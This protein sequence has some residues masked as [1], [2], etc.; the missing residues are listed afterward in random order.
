MS[1]LPLRPISIVTLQAMAA[2][3]V[4]AHAWADASQQY[5]QVEF[6]DQFLNSGGTDKVDISRFN[7]GQQ[8]LPG[9][10][11]AETFVNEV[12]RGRF[13]VEIR[14]SAP[15]SSEVRPCFNADLLERIGVDLRKLSP[16]TTAMLASP[17]N[18]CL[19]LSDLIPSAFASFDGGEQRLDISIPQI[20]MFSKARGY[21]DPKYWD[22][23]VPAA[24][25][26]YNA[27]AYHSSASGYTNDSQYLGLIGGLNAGPWR[28]RYQGN[29]T[30]SSVGGQ[31]YQTVQTYVQRGFND[32]KSQLT[33]GDTFTDG[34]LF[35]SYGVRGVTLGTDD[36]MYPE[37][38][39]GYA[40]IVRGIANSNAR[41]QVR[42]N[43]NVIYETTVAPG[44]FEIT[45]LYP[46]GYGGNL[47]VIVT[48]ADGSQHISTVPYA[49]TVNA[50][51]PGITRYNAMI[52]QYR[53]P[54][55][56]IHPF[57]SQFTIQRGISN[58]LTLYG[59]FTG[60]D[61]YFAG[62][63]GA[64]INTKF[65][66]FGFDAT[67]ATASFAGLGT[68]NGMSFRVS[69]SQLLEPTNTNIAIAAYRYS[70]NGFFS[71]SDAMTMRQLHE[72]SQLGLMSAMQKSRMQFT[73]NQTLGSD[74]RF[75]S[76]YAIGSI[77]NYWNRP[78][79]DTQLQI[80][81]SNSWKR[82]TYGASFVR[83]YMVNT[84]KWDN[85]VMVNLM[86]PLGLGARAPL[87]STNFQ[88]DSADSA[89]SMQ[90]SVTG[91]LGSDSA[92]SYGVNANYNDGGNTGS[93]ATSV[94]ANVGY[95]APFAQLT[96]N[97]STGRHYSQVGAGISGG[98]VAWKGG[99][100]FT[101]NMAE[102]IG[103]VEAK[104][105]AGARVANGAGLRVDPWGHAIVSGMQPYSNN[106]VEI[107]PK[108]LPMNIALK[109]TVQRTAPTAGAVVSL[110]FDTEDTGRAAVM[111]VAQADGKP[112]P[113]GAEVFDEKSN[114]VG[115]VAQGS[116]I[117]ATGLKIDAGTLN[118][119]WGDAPNQTCSVR[120]QLPEQSKANKQLSL[121]IADGV[122]E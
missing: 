69:Y 49:A 121:T 56:D 118:V 25:L 96:A 67:H 107:D 79:R 115:V 32:I 31:H 82:I 40:P 47:D 84:N 111:R 45:D 21:V 93:S 3:G 50:L 104:D 99:V 87:S 112:L 74:G 11:R 122:C 78:G 10:Y 108:G 6:N 85:R 120:Y 119:K 19:A 23:G 2:M 41:V 28:F 20:V 16:E 109:S 52:G 97:G 22:D 117:I 35:D 18:A 102:T 110:K 24:T 89:Y 66:A 101:P 34:A 44:A 39:R 62:M 27:N 68:H 98:V 83:Q 36:R 113:F 26:Q 30:N 59:G 9:S 43:G 61:L 88:Y 90:E 5:A 55:L 76:A 48:E 4:S 51:R 46:T 91:T 86:I 29:L 114:N 116:R 15:G 65:G 60:A 54:S 33:L 38:Q 95:M 72:D 17:D 53:D 13:D 106:D 57:V 63:V 100:A 71:L 81:Y 14:E 75:G 64:A 80:G 105:A 58:L 73:V 103:I 12:W 70:T 8:T 37:S 92:F 42:Q 1:G 94:G 77:V 7:K